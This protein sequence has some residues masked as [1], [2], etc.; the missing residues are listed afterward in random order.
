MDAPSGTYGFMGRYEMYYKHDIK[1]DD[2][3]EVAVYD[4]W[5]V[6]TLLNTLIFKENS[7]FEIGDYFEIKRDGLQPD[8]RGRLISIDENDA[9]WP[10]RVADES[11]NSA[12]FSYYELTKIHSVI[13]QKRAPKAIETLKSQIEIAKAELEAL[14]TALEVL[15][16]ASA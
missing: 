11:G 8:L 12:T 2:N 5:S 9:R 3:G 7:G 1:F 4:G 13:S 14:E 6:G 15:M 16:Y 10:Y